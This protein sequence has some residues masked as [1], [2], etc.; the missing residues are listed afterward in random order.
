MKP[1]KNKNRSK[2]AGKKGK[3]PNNQLSSINFE[4]QGN[5]ILICNLIMFYYI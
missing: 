4:G 5:L 3:L 2:Q 1:F